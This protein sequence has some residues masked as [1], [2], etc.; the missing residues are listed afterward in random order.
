MALREFVWR[1]TR[2][3]LMR[4][5]RSLCA[6]SSLLLSV[7]FLWAGEG[8]RLVHLDEP[9]NPWQFDHG[10]PKLIT[11]QWIGEKGVEA[12]AVLAIDDMSGD[13]QHFRD[14]LTPIIERLKVIDGRG[15]VSITCNRPDPKH[16]NMQW[17]LGQGVSLE[18]HTLSHPCPLLQRLDF[19]KASNDYHGCVDLLAQIPNNQSVGFR[20]GCMDGQNTPSPRAYA[21]ILNKVSKEGRF[22]SMSTSVGIVF[23]PE[24]PEVPGKLFGEKLGGAQRFSKYLMTGFVNYIENY[25]YPFVVGNKILE[26]PFVYPNDYTGQA[27]LGPQNQTTIDDFKAAVDATVAKQGAVSLCF[28]AGGWMRNSQM[29]EIVD[30]SVRTHGKKVKFLNMREMH[31]LMVKNMFAGHPLRNAKGGDNG[32]R[33]LDIDNDGY[34]DV[35]IGNAKA[36]LS[37]IWDPKKSVWRE[38]PFPTVVSSGLRFGVLDEGGR[39]VVMETSGGK[40]RAWRFDGNAWVEDKRLV[41]GLD[42][43]KTRNGELD[44]GVR[45]LDIDGDG[46]CELVVGASTE[47]AVYRLTKSGWS[48]L[49]FGLPEGTAIVTAKSG[50][51]GLRFADIDDDGKQDVIFSNGDH[52]GTWMF[53]SWN[54]GWSRKGLA[55][56][57]QGDGVAE[58]HT[59]KR[60]E[61]APIVRRDGS[62]NGAWIKRGYLYWQTE[63]TGAIFPH[64][65]DQRTFGELLGE[66]V[67]QPRSPRA[68]LRAMQARPGFKVELVAAEPLVMD[69]VDVAWGPDGRLWVAEMAD[70]PM[71][72]DHKGKPGSRIAFLSDTNGDGHYDKRTLFAEGLETANT[73]LPWRDGVLAVAP[74][75]IWFLRDT[76]GDG[77]ADQKD[78]LYAGFGRGNEQHRGNGLAWG[79]D[80]WVYVANGDSG[81][82]IRSTKTGKKLGLGGF[83]LRIKPD[84]GEL[85]RASGV[86]Q[87]ARNRDDWGNWIGGNNSNSWQYVLEDHQ[88]RRNPK[89]SQPAARHGLKSV[90]DLYPISKVLSHYSGYRAPPAGSPGRLTSGCGHTFYRDSLF[91]GVIAPSI[92]YS[93]PVHNCVHREEITWNGVLM[94]TDRASDEKRSEFLRSSDSWF[95][96]TSIRTGPDGGMYV[97]DLYRL[98]IEHPEWIDDTLEKQMIADGRL[99]YGHEQGRIFKLYPEGAK[100][101]KPA[102]LSGKKPAQLAAALDSSNGWQRDTAHMM[103]TWLPKAEQGE[104]IPALLEVLQSTHAVARAQALSALADLGA[105]SPQALK[106]GL[107]D[108]HPGVRRNALRV[109]GQVL[110]EDAALG[111]RAAALLDDEDAHV[112]QEAAY[113]LGYWNDPRAGRALGHFLVKNADRPYL[114][115]AALTSAGAFPHEVLLAVMGMERTAVT[116][117]LSTQ[118][119]GMLG[120]DAKKL[121]PP[122]LQRM[123]KGP[124]NG[125]H[126]QA[127]EFNAASSLMDAVGEGDAAR[128][129]VAPMLSKARAILVDKKKDV[130]VRLAAVSFLQ[131]AAPANSDAD[132]LLA[133]LKLSTP[134]ELQVAAARSVLHHESAGI[135]KILLADWQAYGPVVRG[136]IIDALLARLKLTEVLLDEIADRKGMA[137]SIDVSRRQLL[138]NHE[139]EGLRKRATELLGGATNSDRASVLKK[140]ES[141]LSQKGDRAKGIEVF[142]A[143]CASCHRLGG[144]GKVVGPNLAALSNRAS[145][146]FLNAILDPNQAIEATW[147]LFIAKTK[148]GSTLAGAVAEETSSA[149][150]LV[151]VD[152]TRTKIPRGKLASL[153]STGRSLMPEGLEDAI[154][155]EQMADLIAYLKAAGRP[156]PQ[157]VVEGS[158]IRHLDDKHDGFY[159]IMFDPVPGATAIEFVWENT[160]QWKHWTLREIEAYANFGEKIDIVSGTVLPG[161][162]RTNDNVFKNAFDGKVDN[163]T[164]ITPPYTNKA[165]QR[166]LLA[167]EDGAHSLDRIRINHVGGNDTNG[168]MKRITIRVAKDKGDLTKR[169]YV[170]VANVAVQ[171]FGELEEEEEKP[172]GKPA[173]HGGKPHKIPGLIEAENYDEGGP[174]VGYSDVDAKNH[175]APYRKDTEVD[176]EKRD[177]ASNGHGIGWT[178][179]GEWLGYTVE[180]AEAGT[181]EI[182]IPV[183]SAKMGGLFHFEAGEDVVSKAIRLP[184]TG[185]WKILKKITHKMKLKKG[186]YQMRV[187]MDKDGASGF[188]GDID[189]F[190][191]SKVE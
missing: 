52:F 6:V 162:K 106:I 55:G 45:F 9:N 76:T 98:V 42:D 130:E 35:I 185:G 32:V 126:Y 144:V 30:H 50:D 36:K 120:E 165:P 141:V 143:N 56:K 108:A 21:E 79:L 174:G 53:S 118:V 31:E 90:I 70:Y 187:V 92:Y 128:G 184:D 136:A 91:G 13:G 142:K 157:V 18:T 102:R 77:K 135:A 189:Y 78:V 163:F 3:R 38:V 178:K 101:H 171:I 63:D 146:T 169:K 107:H 80:G 73:V 88:V 75:N 191:F 190:K 159:S 112:Q 25:P 105:L 5:H 115:A 48:K 64:H 54:E 22:M 41:A 4:S 17:L 170:D 2:L 74:P 160:G 28:H 93:C 149:I 182:E 156:M 97:A 49:S 11:P 60:E 85:E 23:T 127:W 24:D 152:G 65:I 119:M 123:A 26:L 15:P 164:Y 27:L 147:M 124:D 132:R 100:L 134:I 20:F 180:V 66:Q 10:S 125:K 87:H 94:K 43:V 8:S 186:T 46:V 47:T 83:D 104:A 166:T 82:T 51:A 117:A 86:T 122:V 33:V 62:N 129:L 183:A 96:P 99:R 68:S 37:R 150:T 110:N 168:P 151:G 114:R 173:P 95:R 59:R 116:S 172:K 181:Y 81:G 138:L 39:A 137:A 176:I 71:G 111:V 109:G 69:P 67:N 167:L 140:Y 113:A 44:G 188:V 155:P 29:V 161:P 72:I 84:T 34:M 61:L 40:N 57:R 154:N 7:S 12:V 19:N 1:K 148:D 179:A 175:G 153:E 177:D 145:P 14:Y 16:P 103:L 158:T 89:V 58:Q 131:R 133:L 139:D 121:I